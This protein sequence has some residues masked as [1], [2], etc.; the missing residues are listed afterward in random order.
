M[1]SL[2]LGNVCKDL[3]PNDNCSTLILNKV[4]YYQFYLNTDPESQF[5]QCDTISLTLLLRI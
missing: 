1:I 2:S 3:F 4:W 5:V